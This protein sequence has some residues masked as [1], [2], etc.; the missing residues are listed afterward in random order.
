MTIFN[1]QPKGIPVGGQ[2][3]ATA[4]AEPSLH[5]SAGTQELGT[6]DTGDMLGAAKDML[7]NALQSHRDRIEARRADRTPRARINPVKRRLAVAALVLA[8]TTS[9]TACSGQSNDCPKAAD[10]P[11]SSQSVSYAGTS[12]ANITTASF[13][14]KAGGGGHGHSSGHSSEGGSA[15]HSEGDGSSS[16]GSTGAHFWPWS[17]GAH[18]NQCTAHPAPAKAS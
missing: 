3:A 13:V 2:F 16:S 5:L 8:A 9:M 11:T 6:R 12:T 10:F 4:H 17:T 7:R 1:R 15:G 14:M 18:S